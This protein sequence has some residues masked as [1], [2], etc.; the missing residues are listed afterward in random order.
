MERQREHTSKSEAPFAF[1][2]LTLA[3]PIGAQPAAIIPT[4]F[5]ENRIAERWIGRSI[6]STAAYLSVA[7]QAN[8]SLNDQS[9]G[10]LDLTAGNFTKNHMQIANVTLNSAI[11]PTLINQATIGFQYWN[12]LIDSDKRVP[13]VTFLS[14]E[15]F[16]TNTNVPQN[17]IQRKYQFKDDLSKTMGR[18]TLK[19]GIDYIYTPFMGGFFEFNP[20]LE[21]DFGQDPSCILGVGP[22]PVRPAAA[23]PLSRKALPL[24]GSCPRQ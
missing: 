11:S 5:F 6:P 8:N 23:R 9:D 12:N 17:S 4:P 1:T 20:T 22:K 10:T 2:E 3:A 21:I 18:H 16:G 24:P 15:Q 14:G 19:T 13:L 7:T